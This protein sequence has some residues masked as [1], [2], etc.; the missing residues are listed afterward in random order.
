MSAK[1]A[2]HE[3]QS[4][5]GRKPPGSG[6]HGPLERVTVNLTVRAARALNQAAELT[7]DSK[8][9]TINRALQ[10]YAYLEQ[11]THNGGAIYVRETPDGEPQLIKMFLLALLASPNGEP[12][13]AAARSQR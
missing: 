4:N 6:Q 7:G 1:G 11:I 13:D 5:Q 2:V 10:I 9:D 3:N 8:T 12:A